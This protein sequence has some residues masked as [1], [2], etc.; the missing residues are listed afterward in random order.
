MKKNEE[1]E[2][3]VRVDF[4][5]VMVEVE[6]DTFDECDLRKVIGNN[7]HRGCA[8]LDMDEIGR[9][10]NREGMA[11]IPASRI[12]EV[13]SIISGAPIVYAYKVAALTLLDKAK[14]E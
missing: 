1:S 13:H 10:I 11:D 12:D 9:A 2:K 3:T 7:I 5:K 4:S 6:Y 14:E 8:D